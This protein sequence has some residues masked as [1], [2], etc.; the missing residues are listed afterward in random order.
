MQ[1]Y[2]KINQIAV[3]LRDYWKNPLYEELKEQFRYFLNAD[4]GGIWPYI[5]DKY[6]NEELEAV[7]TR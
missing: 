3:R 5:K 6:A 4:P 2:R 7:K 1:E